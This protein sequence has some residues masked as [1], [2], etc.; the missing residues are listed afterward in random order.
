MKKTSN[1]MPKLENETVTPDMEATQAAPHPAEIEADRLR[2]ELSNERI[3]VEA[4]SRRCIRLGEALDAAILA[5]DNRVEKDMFN[6]ING[7][8]HHRKAM[9]AENK[10]RKAHE[11]KMAEAFEDACTKNAI[12]LC[13]SALVAFGAIILGYAGFI[14]TAVAAIIAGGAA[15]AFGWALNDCA[16]LLGRCAK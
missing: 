5:E 11:R 14:H 1:D 6:H 2:I 7:N 12:A 9:I 8:C 13:A 16:Y 3:K 4:L 10:R 15:I